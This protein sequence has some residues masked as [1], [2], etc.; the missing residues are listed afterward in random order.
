MRRP[1]VMAVPMMT[2]MTASVSTL[3]LPLV[4]NSKITLP[5]SVTAWLNSCARAVLTTVCTVPTSAVRRL[6]RSPVLCEAKNRGLSVSRCENTA[7]RRSATTEAPM[8][9]SR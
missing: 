7:R 3:S 4:K 9:D 1:M 2:G 8:R 5:T 6:V